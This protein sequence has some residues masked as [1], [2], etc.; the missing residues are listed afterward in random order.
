M[1]EGQKI[2][3]FQIMS[4]IF[5]AR[6][7]LKIEELGE[8]LSVQ[9]DSDDLQEVLIPELDSVV[10]TCESLVEV[11]RV[12]HEVRFTHQTVNEF[13]RDHCKSQMLSN[14]DLAKV[15]LVYLAFSEFEEPCKDKVALKRRRAKYKFSEYAIEFWSFYT[16]GAGEGCVEVRKRL[17]SAFKSADKCD[18]YAQI[19]SNFSSFSSEGF[20]MPFLHIVAWN[21]LATIC[22]MLLDEHSEEIRKY[23][24]IYLH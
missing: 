6:R 12:S 18:S 9:E 7:V 21:G 8:A 14:I 13:L 19:S 16:R 4:W 5:R 22:Q 24:P 10:N 1:E 17:Y 15:C 23:V 3:A 2:F 20:D 11:D